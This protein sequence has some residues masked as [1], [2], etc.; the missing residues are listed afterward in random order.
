MTYVWFVTINTGE[1]DRTSPIDSNAAHTA[2]MDLASALRDGQAAIAVHPGYV[3]AAKT[4][5]S[6]LICTVYKGGD[7]PIST[8]GVAGRSRDSG[9][10]WRMLHESAGYRL[11]TNPDIPPKAPWC[12]VRVEPSALLD[13]DMPFIWLAGYEMEIAWAWITKQ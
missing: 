10:L 5:G 2:A 6:A 7:L 3:I 9:A 4:V 12:A 11:A 13:Q 8:F 1:A